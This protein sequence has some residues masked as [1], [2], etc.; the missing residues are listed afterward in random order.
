QAFAGAH[1][2]RRSR[3][4]TRSALFLSK[5]GATLVLIEGGSQTGR[6]LP[7]DY[8]SPGP[9]SGAP[10][11]VE[12]MKKFRPSLNFTVLPLALGVPF[13]AR[14]P[15]M[16]TSLPMTKSVLRRPFLNSAFGLP[17]SIA[18]FTAFPSA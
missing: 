10:V 18:Q 6:D 15:L 3:L 2:G 4:W 8:L 9:S 14:N 1:G 13:L 16:R 5:G 7:I 17:A 11:P 12:P